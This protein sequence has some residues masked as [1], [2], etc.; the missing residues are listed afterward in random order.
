MTSSPRA[1]AKEN[2]RKQRAKCDVIFEPGSAKQARLFKPNGLQRA[3]TKQPIEQPCCAGQ[4]PTRAKKKQC[5]QAAPASRKLN[6]QRNAKMLI[7]R[8]A[9]TQRRM[10]QGT[11]PQ[12]RRASPLLACLGIATLMHCMPTRSIVRSVAHHEPLNLPA[13]LLF[14]HVVQLLAVRILSNTE[15]ESHVSSRARGCMRPATCSSP[16]R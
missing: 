5:K 6:R 11:W 16:A 2:K 13:Q 7:Q 10:P 9:L 15:D 4:F 14:H 8:L 3:V 12:P 1:K